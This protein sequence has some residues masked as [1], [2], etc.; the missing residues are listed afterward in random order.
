MYVWGF[1]GLWEM[2]ILR[3]MRTEEK[4][5]IKSYKN[6]YFMEKLKLKKIIK[7]L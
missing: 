7:K 1:R 6:Y 4:Q 5:F 3:F 2:K